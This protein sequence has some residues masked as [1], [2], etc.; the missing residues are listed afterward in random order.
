MKQEQKEGLMGLDNLRGPMQNFIINLRKN[1]NGDIWCFL[2]NGED[3][4][5]FKSMLN[6]QTIAIIDN[7]DDFPE[8][9]KY[10]DNEY[11]IYLGGA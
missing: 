7:E 2:S 10:L 9:K 1:Y 8:F 5:E 11:S 6:N 3:Y 4:W